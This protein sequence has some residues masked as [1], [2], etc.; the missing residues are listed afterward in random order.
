MAGGGGAVTWNGASAE[1]AAGLPGFVT[2]IVK[3]PTVLK[4]DAGNVAV[5]EVALTTVAVNELVPNCTVAFDANC[6]PVRLR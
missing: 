3:L 6:D 4:S 2:V 1:T 5:I